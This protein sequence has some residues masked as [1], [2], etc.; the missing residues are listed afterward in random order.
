MRAQTSQRIQSLQRLQVAERLD[1]SPEAVD[2]CG[3]R[4]PSHLV[5][6]FQGDVGS[7]VCRR[8]RAC[9]TCPS[10]CR[11]EPLDN[12]QHTASFLVPDKSNEA[13]HRGWKSGDRKSTRL[14]SSHMSI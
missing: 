13:N 12:S 3:R 10:P 11:A 4:K 7:E 8:R 9:E 6:F 14:N 5:S 1:G 2:Q